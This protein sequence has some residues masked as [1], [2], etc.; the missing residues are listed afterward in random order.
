MENWILVVG[1][2]R[3]HF[4]AARTE[5]LK[6]NVYLDSTETAPDAIIRFLVRQY[7]AVIASYNVSNITQLI[8]FMNGTKQ[9]PLVILSQNDSGTK[10]AET[11]MRG[12]NT[13]IID[14]D[15]LIESINENRDILDRLA[16]LPF[17]ERKAL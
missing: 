14:P 7:I 16:K 17:G 5:W 4:E 13:F 6:Y 9:V 3:L 2:D 11:I 8:D 15:K 12:A 10:F 1:Y